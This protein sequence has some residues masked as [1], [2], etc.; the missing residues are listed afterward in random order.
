M[1]SCASGSQNISSI[2]S[3]I[4][5]LTKLVVCHQSSSFRFQ[6]S[7]PHMHVY[8]AN[9]T[10][11]FTMHAVYETWFINAPAATARD[12]SRGLACDMFAPVP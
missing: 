10:L 4:C 8:Q 12:P 9:T 5:L 7:P 1:E 3:F 6:I 2:H 11:L